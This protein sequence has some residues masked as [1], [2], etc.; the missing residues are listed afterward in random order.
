MHGTL[1]E[2]EDVCVAVTVSKIRAAVDDLAIA[3]RPVMVHTSM[4]SFGQR[5]DGG[6]DA[7]LD[8]LLSRGCTVMVPA[9]T[10]P[11]FGVRPEPSM[12]P[13][14]NGADHNEGEASGKA[15]Y[16]ADCGQINPGM[17]AVPARLIARPGARR[18]G[19]PLNS[20]AALGPAAADLI[21]GQSPVDVYAPIRALA[22][23]GGHVLLIGVGLNRMTA[24]HLAEQRS[25]RRL[26]V[27][28]ARRPGGG[29]AAV[30]VGSCSEGFPRLE[31]HLREHVRTT[32]VARA[33]WR[34]YPAREAVHT[35]SMV[36]AADPGV[37]R[38]SDSCVRCRDS[39]DGGPIGPAPLG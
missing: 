29:I 33:L 4:R 20:F 2:R 9:F 5:V 16:T 31:P 32:K 11:Q 38:C 1:H 27:R 36:M 24:L 10:E 37:T 6:P 7:V 23:L 21:D 35:A 14:R 19:H 18:G 39:I 28:W 3:G 17:G 26:F 12:R 30:E 15:V 25:G 13:A 8:A 22:A 34:A